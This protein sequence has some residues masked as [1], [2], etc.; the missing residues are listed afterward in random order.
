MNILQR[1]K[2]S[3]ELARLEKRAHESPSPSIYVDMAQ[4]YI[5][6]GMLDQTVRVAEEGLALF[7]GSDELKRVLK[8]ARKAKLNNRIKEIRNK[9]H[10][11]P[12][13]ALYRELATVYMELGDFGAV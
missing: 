11:A 6:L 8:F 10:K 2:I 4:V 7:P 12:A 5:N 13:P 1:F 3:R 9:I